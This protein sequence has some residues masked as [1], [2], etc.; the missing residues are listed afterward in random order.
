MMGSLISNSIQLEMLVMMNILM[1]PKKK[2]EM[3]SFP[4]GH[5]NMLVR[6][7]PGIDPVIHPQ[8][9]DLSISKQKVKQREALIEMN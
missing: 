8:P 2:D 5:F 4:V 7:R 1:L 6:K 3:A 9:L